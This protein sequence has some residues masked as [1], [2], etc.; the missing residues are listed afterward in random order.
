MRTLPSK[1]RSPPHHRRHPT[2]QG[3]TQPILMSMTL[4]SGHPAA[5]G[6][7]HDPSPRRADTRARRDSAAFPTRA[8][9]T[10]KMPSA[11]DNAT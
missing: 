8:N 4:S 7:D 9:R 10:L 3:S 2:P 5:T 1:R 11:P 6:P